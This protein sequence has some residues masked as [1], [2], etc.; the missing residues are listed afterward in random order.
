[1][2]KDKKMVWQNKY[3]NIRQTYNGRSYM[4]KAEAN[5]AYEL[6]LMKKDHNAMAKVS[7]WQGQFKVEF[8]VTPKAE[9]YSISS[10]TK[11]VPIKGDRKIVTHYV[12]FVVFYKS[13]KTEL[14][15]VKGMVTDLYRLKKILL[16][17]TFLRENPEINYLIFN[18]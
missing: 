10:L 6:D 3:K 4:S 12:D 11:R 5:H 9:L 14:H 15:E 17:V 7:D 1:M 18:A 13:G 2:G 16:E 8:Y